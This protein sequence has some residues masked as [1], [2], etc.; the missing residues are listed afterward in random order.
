MIPRE[1]TFSVHE[2]ENDDERG[3]MNSSRKITRLDSRLLSA[4]DE[5][6]MYDVWIREWV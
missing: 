3:S 1:S 6:E 2:V 5:E 4:D